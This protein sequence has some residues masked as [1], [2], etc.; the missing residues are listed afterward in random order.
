MRVCE[1]HYLSQT[2]FAGLAGGY[3][4]RKVSKKYP[5]RIGETPKRSQT[6]Y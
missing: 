5:W 3:V 2:P 4:A 1:R 6:P